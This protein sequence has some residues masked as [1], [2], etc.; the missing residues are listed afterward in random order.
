MPHTLLQ[1]RLASGM[2]DEAPSSHLQQSQAL[3][4]AKTW[5][6]RRFWPGNDT[7]EASFGIQIESPILA[8][9]Q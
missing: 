2:A 7:S 6:M 5:H 3:H 9:M 8:E 4:L 1:G